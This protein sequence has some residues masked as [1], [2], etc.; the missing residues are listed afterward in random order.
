[1]QQ[2]DDGKL[3]VSA[4]KDAAALSRRQAIAAGAV[5]GLVTPS[6]VRGGLAQPRAALADEAPTEATPNITGEDSPQEAA[7]AAA[8]EITGEGRSG[9]TS[10]D[11]IELGRTGVQ[12]P[13]NFRQ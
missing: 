13:A 8:A 9:S 11:L 4:T 7:G 10:M 12:L 3:Y 1:M 6:I 2:S 5:G